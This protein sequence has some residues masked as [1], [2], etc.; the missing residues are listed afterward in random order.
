MTNQQ[1]IALQVAAD[2]TARAGRVF[3]S[4]LA[5][6]AADCGVPGPTLSAALAIV[7][8]GL[9]VELDG[10]ATDGARIAV[11]VEQVEET[12]AQMRIDR[13]CQGLN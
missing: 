2:D 11:F 5:Q 8:A 4:Y 13:D 6:I 9:L 12:I 10:R 3:A 1:R 7:L